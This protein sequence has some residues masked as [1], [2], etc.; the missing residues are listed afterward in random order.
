M[1]KVQELN[2]ELMRLASF[3]C[4]DGER[5]VKDLREHE[6]VW[7]GAVMTRLDSGEL[8]ALRDVAD[9]YWNVD[10]LY[11]LPKAGKEDELMILAL[12]WDADEV[13]WIAGRE[14]VHYLGEYSRELEANPK[15][16]LRIW[17]D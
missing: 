4:Y 1:N 12:H 8:I 15:A 7:N 17:W 5:V 13:D 11:I 10:T 14:A 16:M 3:N 2:L 9:D 6:D